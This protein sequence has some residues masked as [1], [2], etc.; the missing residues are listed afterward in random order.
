MVVLS[1][2][3]P[4]TEGIKLVQSNTGAFIN[5]RDLGSGTLYIA[6]SRVSWVSASS[7]EGFSLEYPHISLHAVSKDLSSFPRE[8][9]YLML[10]SK[11]EE[12]ESPADDE[13]DDEPES[14]M[15][16]VRFIPEDRGLLDAMFHA[17]SVCQTLHPDPNDSVSDDGDF[18]DTEEGEYC[19]EAAE[20]GEHENGDNEE[21][22]QMEVGQ[23]EDADPEH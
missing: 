8:C 16:E 5:S 3:P 21:D 6:E 2:F 19:L 14:D 17:M 20:A 23:F 12:S 7:G 13:S 10:D 9:L 15:S 22:E 1:S 18:E 11:L 4:P